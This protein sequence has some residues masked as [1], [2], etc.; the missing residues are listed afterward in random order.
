[1]VPL[2][3]VHWVNESIDGTIIKQ[4]CKYGAHSRNHKM[5]WRTWK[6]LVPEAASCLL[7]INSSI[8]QL[9]RLSSSRLG[10]I[11][12]FRP[13]DVNVTDLLMIITPILSVHLKKI[14]SAC[15]VLGTELDVEDTQTKASCHL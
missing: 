11:F 10:G 12:R 9:K 8:F 15:Y 1:M 4:L 6:R 14:L 7:N 2:L 13:K 3:F 5:G